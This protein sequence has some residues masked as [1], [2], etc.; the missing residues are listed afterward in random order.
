MTGGAPLRHAG[1]I[2]PLLS[3]GTGA[4]DAFAFTALGGIFTANMTGN[5]VLAA[6]VTRPDYLGTLAGA[7]T[8]LCSFAAALFLGFRITRRSAQVAVPG[9]AMLIALSMSAGFLML[10]TLLWW[11]APLSRG[12]HIGMI[13]ASA[14]AMA[15]QTV[16]AKRD[17]V[18]R[19]ATTTYLT[20][21][22]TDVIQDIVE[23]TISWR[24]IRW[25]PLLALPF[26]AVVAVATGMLWPD[27]T[28]LLPLATTGV[29]MALIAAP[30]NGKSWQGQRA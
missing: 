19:G 26:G 23:R 29:S 14:A 12:V 22:L 8:A 7:A 15:F 2:L 11:F 5:A 20:G 27:M 17:G 25:L 1:L 16:A 4:A 10:V 9:V 21:T 13:A 24:S 3:F 28:P 6:I 18:P 30:L